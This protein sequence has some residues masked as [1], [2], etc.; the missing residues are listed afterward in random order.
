MNKTVTIN[1]SGIIFHIEEDAYDTLSKYLTTIRGYFVN[2][3]DKDEIMSDIEARIAELLKEKVSDYKQVV[4]MADVDH[5]MNIMGKP[6]DFAGE[7]AGQSNSSQESTT[8]NPNRKRR[9]YRDPD[10]KMI[11]G[12][13]SGISHYFD[14]D[15]TIVR[16]ILAV[17][18]FTTFG[19]LITIYVILWMIIPEAKT[20]AEKLEMRGESIDI[21]NIS[22]TVK[23]EA[24]QLKARMEKYG[25]TGG[26]KLGDFLKQFFNIVGKVLIKLIGLA[27][28]FIGI[29]LMIFAIAVMFHKTA[30][31]DTDAQLYVDDFFGTNQILVSLGA[32]IVAGVPAIM[33]LYKGIKM[34]FGIRY[35]NK[36]L[37]IGSG[38]LWT[39]GLIIL[40]FAAADM[41]KEFKSEGK[42]KNNFVVKNAKQ[43]TLYIAADLKNKLLEQFESYQEV[44]H[45]GKIRIGG[46]RNSSVQKID[47]EIYGAVQVNV[48]ESESDSFEINII[49]IANGP[50]KRLALERA[51]KISYSISQ[52]D[53]LIVVDPLFKLEKGERLR[54]QNV[55]VMIGVPK[56]KVVKLDKSLYS[57]LH[58]VDN[59]T[60]T[61]DG[62]MVD[63]RWKMTARG[64]QCID[65]ENLN[66]EDSD[67]DIDVDL[68]GP[69]NPPVPPGIHIDDKDATVKMDEKGIDIKSKEVQIKMDKDGINIKTKDKKD[70]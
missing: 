54:G 30:I 8:I 41:S 37:N 17:L 46:F 45:M 47:E 2:A 22:K 67:F 13:C 62:D 18:A 21:N 57:F 38:V 1:I 70:N 49:K 35:H 42:V 25:R 66:V 52:N 36:W 51:R 19:V 6:E 48:V 44:R 59:V 60:N 55:T 61:W 20:T 31:N 28:V 29:I 34:L 10:D 56:G 65:C 24:E 23:E 64:L 26:S 58:D 16:V 7:E 33:L 40:I 5:V 68:P 50:D 27:L 63:R 9:F 15:P 32:V 3:Q 14:I 39:I 4:L 11:G 53:S 43:D 69:P 12:V